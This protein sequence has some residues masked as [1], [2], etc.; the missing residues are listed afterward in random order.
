MIRKPKP[1]PTL[2]AMNERTARLHE[3]MR[4]RRLNSP[5]VGEMLGR[6]SQT[7]R[8]WRCESKIIPE[9][10]LLALEQAVADLDKKRT[11]EATKKRS[12]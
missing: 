2:P 10:T 8:M 4:T 3:I 11:A 6:S 7:V 1:A 12:R 9:H 5:D